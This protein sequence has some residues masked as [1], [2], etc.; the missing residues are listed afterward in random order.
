MSP[1]FLGWNI[2][3]ILSL[4]IMAYARCHLHRNFVLFSDSWG[5]GVGIGLGVHG[6]PTMI[7]TLLFGEHILGIFSIRLW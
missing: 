2:Y 5:P 3:K 4:H 1:Y 6:C 7:A